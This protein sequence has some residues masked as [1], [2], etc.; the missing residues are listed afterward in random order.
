MARGPRKGTRT[1]KSTK[2]AGEPD[3]TI[4]DI[5][6][7]IE[8]PDPYSGISREFDKFVDLPFLF[9]SR[10]AIYDDFLYGK[11]AVSRKTNFGR[12]ASFAKTLRAF[13]AKFKTE[14]ISADEFDRRF[15]YYCMSLFSDTENPQK[16]YH[17][18]ERV[19]M[20]A[21]VARDLIPENP[22]EF[23]RGKVRDAPS[24]ADART[25]LNRAK[26]DAWEVIRRRELAIQLNELG[27]HPS[28]ERGGKRGDAAHLENRLFACREMMAMGI[29]GET[30]LYAKK[31]WGL[32]GALRERPG[33]IVIDPAKGPVRLNGVMAHVHF[34]HPSP[35]DLFPFVCILML[36]GMLN[37]ATVCESKVT[38]RLWTEYPYVLDPADAKDLVM[39]ILLKHRG[40]AQPEEITK[41][42]DGKLPT[43]VPREIKFPSSTRPWSHPYKI[44]N[45]LIELTE[46]LRDD[47]LQRIVLLRS[48]KRRTSA[49]EEELRHLTAI[50]D[51]LFIYRTKVGVGSL[52][53]AAQVGATRS[54]VKML[55]RYGLSGATRDLRDSGLTY[56]F[57]A[58]G[59]NVMI[60]KT[61][62]GHKDL[63]TS[64]MYARRR[65]TI[66]A[67]RSAMKDVAA[68]ALVLARNKRF[69]TEQLR[70]ILANQG[71]P[72]EQIANVIDKKKRTRFESGCLDP[73]SPPQ[74]FNRGTPA[75]QM[76]RLQDCIDGCSNA[77]FLPASLPHFIRERL[78]HRA[79]LEFIG[80]MGAETSIIGA[81][82]QNLDNLIAHFPSRTV[83]RLEAKIV[84]ELSN[85]KGRGQQDATQ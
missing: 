63:G 5:P 15:P 24:D 12:I 49:E 8:G 6:H 73:Y 39:I 76:C 30:E 13:Q 9:G 75:G 47:I 31:H 64:G 60:L 62:A 38:D 42:V 56:S 80:P 21:G 59:W 3:A 10:K 53:Q 71:I 45:F 81:R 84:K 66:E 55:R 32:L 22:F 54:M 34:Y 14:I 20:A 26:A 28:R 83:E 18:F 85:Q 7:Q 65:Q 25:A 68:K 50:K 36:R 72:A 79:Q 82:I 19:A 2:G 41:G 77:R 17:D 1:G 33:A 35:H 23:K 16:R 69:S 37:L 58:S 48:I 78:K 29:Y 27:H 46:P 51:D 52:Q 67:A 4:A 57:R 40:S 44:L 61:L 43:G 11:K 70:K 74:G